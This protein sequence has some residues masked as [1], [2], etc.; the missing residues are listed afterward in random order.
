MKHFWRLFKKHCPIDEHL[1]SNHRN[2]N[3]IGC[4][5][6]AGEYERI[7]CSNSSLLF[8]F[9]FIQISLFICQFLFLPSL[10]LAHTIQTER[11]HFPKFIFRQSE[12]LN[13]Y[14]KEME[15]QF[16]FFVNN[17]HKDNISIDH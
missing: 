16:P 12:K 14:H 5:E 13:S 9:S 6:P 3:N 7:L 15:Q 2:N 1:N 17:V 11:F 8:E 10:S 4:M